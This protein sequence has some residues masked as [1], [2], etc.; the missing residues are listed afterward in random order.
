MRCRVRR[1]R[2]RPP[3]PADDEQEQPAHEGQGMKV[4]I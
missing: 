1:S 3:G 2:E 4:G